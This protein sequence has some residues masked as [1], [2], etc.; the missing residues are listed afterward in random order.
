MYGG[1]IMFVIKYTKYVNNEWNLAGIIDKI[2]KRKSFAEKYANKFFSTSDLKHD[3]RGNKVS[4]KWEILEIEHAGEV[5]H[6]GYIAN[7]DI[8]DD[9][10]HVVNRVQFRNEGELVDFANKNNIYILTGLK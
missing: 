4:Y 3:L 1:T 7:L 2:Y 9:S 8:L 10:N 6:E 5:S